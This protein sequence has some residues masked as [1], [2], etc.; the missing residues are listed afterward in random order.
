MAMTIFSNA[1]GQW[2]KRLATKEEESAADK[3]VFQQQMARWQS[4]LVAIREEKHTRAWLRRVR[5]RGLTPTRTRSS[6]NWQTREQ[7]ASNPSV[8]RRADLTNPLTWS[9]VSP[10]EPAPF[11][12]DIIPRMVYVGMEKFDVYVVEHRGERTREKLVAPGFSRDC[13]GEDCGKM[14]CAGCWAIAHA[15][16][17]P[18]DVIHIRRVPSPTYK[19][20]DPSG[21]HPK[22]LIHSGRQDMGEDQKGLFA[23][24]SAQGQSKVGSGNSDRGEVDRMGRL[25]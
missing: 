3:R 15:A 24:T 2:T 22:G 5:A 18:D 25:K 21:V 4:A 12:W 19:V 16:V 6:Y 1:S 13:N 20:N 14:V 10:G 17:G 23:L 9:F 7:K 8:L 11:N